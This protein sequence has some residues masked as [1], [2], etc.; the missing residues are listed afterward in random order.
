MSD[1]VGVARASFKESRATPPT[2]TDTRETRPVAL[3]SFRPLVIS[4]RSSRSL[5]R[6]AFLCADAS[7]EGC[8]AGCEQPVVVVELDEPPHRRQNRSLPAQ[9]GCS[10]SRDKGPRL[11]EQAVLVSLICHHV[12]MG[13]RLSE[14]GGG[15]PERRE[16]GRLGRQLCVLALVRSAVKSVAPCPH[17]LMTAIVASWTEWSMTRLLLS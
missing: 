11:S 15:C 12:W 16:G 5:S 6:S 1:L 4:P 3:T 2:C 8:R 10:R 9:V 14:G 17:E 7:S 13:P